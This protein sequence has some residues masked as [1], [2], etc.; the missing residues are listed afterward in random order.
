[1]T[2]LDS[3]AV[4]EMRDWHRIAWR[5]VNLSTVPFWLAMIILPRSALTRRLVGAVTPLY[6]TLG[7][8]YVGFIAAAMAA[9]D[10]RVDFMDPESVRRAFQQPE[11][12]LGGWT[13]YIVFDLFVGR[14]IW[15]TALEEGRPARLSL[16][17]TWWFGPAGLTLFLN[18]HRL[19]GALR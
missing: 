15:E 6:L 14:W 16:L 17:L 9:A 18:R 10:E 19:P 3:P 8:A 2:T 4:G 13:H 7:A 1:M 11:G 5:I 12:L